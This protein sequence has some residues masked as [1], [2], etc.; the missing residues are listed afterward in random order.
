M[1][2][3]YSLVL[4]AAACH[5]DGKTLLSPGTMAVDPVPTGRSCAGL[6]MDGFQLGEAMAIEGDVLQVS[7]SY[8]GGC[9][10]H[11]FAACW[12]GTIQ[13]SNPSRIRLTLAHDAHDDLCDA[14]VTRDLFIDIA[15][16]PDQFRVP[17]RGGE[18]TITITEPLR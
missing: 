4:F 7:V 17:T 14:F 6:P 16:L 9:E 13:E 8:G 5:G 11:T 2:L 3:A 1:R 15:E 18:N 10:E 12:D